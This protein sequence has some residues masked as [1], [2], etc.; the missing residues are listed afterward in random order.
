MNVQWKYV[1]RLSAKTVPSV[2]IFVLSCRTA[3]FALGD[4]LAF[5]I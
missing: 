5:G 3:N 2:T 1:D 4:D